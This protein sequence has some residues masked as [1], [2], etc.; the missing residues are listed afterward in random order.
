MATKLNG[1]PGQVTTGD[2]KYLD[3]Q[4]K[5]S[6][7]KHN[8]RSVEKHSAQSY[9]AEHPDN[10]NNRAQESSVIDRK[11]AKAPFT[12]NHLSDLPPLP[13][14]PATK[15]SSPHR[16]IPSHELT[17]LK[18][19]SKTANSLSELGKL[20]EKLSDLRKQHLPD[21]PG[22][23]EV[24]PFHDVRI[25]IRRKA[26]RLVEKHF[27]DPSNPTTKELKAVAKQ[28]SKFPDP[29]AK[30]ALRIAFNLPNAGNK[31]GK[32][33]PN[34]QTVKACVSAS[35]Q[36]IAT[37]DSALGDSIRSGEPVKNTKEHYP[38]SPKVPK[39][40]QP[41][42]SK[43][44]KAP[45]AVNTQRASQNS[46]DRLFT[47]AR[48]THSYSNLAKHIHQLSNNPAWATQQNS[49]NQ[50]TQRLVAEVLTPPIDCEALEFIYHKFISDQQPTSAS[51]A[52][53]DGVLDNC[54]A[55]LTQEPEAAK[56]LLFNICRD[57]A[58]A[59]REY[60]P[61]LE[62]LTTAAS[63][64]RH[65]S[66]SINNGILNIQMAISFNW[67]DSD[68]QEEQHA[69]VLAR[70]QLNN[71]EKYDVIDE[72]DV[73][74]Q[75]FDDDYDL[76]IEKLEE[77]TASFKQDALSTEDTSPPDEA[78]PPAE[79]TKPKTLQHDVLFT[80]TAPKLDNKE[81]YAEPVN[82]SPNDLAARRKAIA[83]DSDSESDL[84]STFNSTLS[85]TARSLE[86]DSVTLIDLEAE[87][88]S[89]EQSDMVNQKAE[90]IP[91][92]PPKAPPPPSIPSAPYIPSA[93][94]GDDRKNL[95][96]D[97]QK[98]IQLRPVETD[99]RPKSS[100]KQQG[101]KI[102]R[103]VMNALANSPM[104]KNKDTGSTNQQSLVVEED[105]YQPPLG[106][107]KKPPLGGSMDLM[108]ELRGRLNEKKR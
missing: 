92:L 60:H 27:K 108:S 78:L 104:L 67:T 33:T 19:A 32:C 79:T 76:F 64:Y 75:P 45:H 52:V 37:L 50:L 89:I 9:K 28:V 54:R 53:L 106:E 5:P 25:S 72:S 1:S 96:L 39:F 91:P 59:S 41:S 3:T 29:R 94:A 70:H 12:K 16:S 82:L 101:D 21:N 80:R 31:T 85:T 40:P 17:A 58:K 20:S 86:Q 34:S 14:Q 26:T 88:D 84:E 38:E 57:L 62:Q 73:D 48:N 8:Q 13:G 63:L 18:T 15:G 46:I 83:G 36:L 22:D 103:P 98:G 68:L 2:Q 11:T 102:A 61:Q 44:T 4:I 7:G 97:I 65:H 99:K 95:L 23:R 77:L 105:S 69:W 87:E 81:Q 56:S 71:P 47:E 74:E 107:A 49:V 55:I 66:Q 93:P 90:D 10:L 100:K 42:P 51:A 35:E 24:M 30:R 6:R 43:K